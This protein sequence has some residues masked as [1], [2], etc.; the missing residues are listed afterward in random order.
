ME[1]YLIR[2]TTPKVAKG[3]CYGQSDLA[4]DD[5]RYSEESERV[6]ESLPAKPD[7]VY[8]SPLKRCTKLAG[9]IAAQFGANSVITDTRLMELDFGDWEMKPWDELTG[10]ALDIWMQD[11]VN[12][13]AGGEESFTGLHQRVGHFLNDLAASSYHRVAVVTHAGVIRSA[14]A[15]FEGVALKG[16]FAYACPYASVRHYKL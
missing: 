1:L 4:I 9:H 15:H 5:S 2:H 6:I 7:A 13:K 11:F 14:I 16:V 10:L 12:Q 8:S 3:I